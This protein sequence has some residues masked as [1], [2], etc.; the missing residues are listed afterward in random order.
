MG[1]FVPE[2]YCIRVEAVHV[3]VSAT[4]RDSD[5]VWAS[6][7]GIMDNNGGGSDRYCCVQDF[8]EHDQSCSGPA[9]GKA[10]P[11]ELSDHARY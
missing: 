10:L 1:N 2:S 8:M 5:M 11:P 3:R 9:F 7:P 4:E 6:R